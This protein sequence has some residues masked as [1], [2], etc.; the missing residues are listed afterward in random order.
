MYVTLNSGESVS[1]GKQHIEKKHAFAEEWDA[2]SAAYWRAREA[3]EPDAFIEAIDLLLPFVEVR[4][5]CSV[6]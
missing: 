4:F 3:P 1:L 2:C 5:E 6:E